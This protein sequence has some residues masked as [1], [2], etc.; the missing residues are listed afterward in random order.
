MR[1]KKVEEGYL[2]RLDPG[3]EV[4]SKLVD[5]VKAEQIPG[6]FITGMGAVERVT[7]G[8]YDYENRSYITKT[9]RDRLE[10][11]NLNGNI[12]YL[13]ETGDPFIHCHVTV[14]DSSL[15]SY[16]GHLFEAIVLV[17]VEIFIRPLKE[18]LMRHRNQE[19]GF[20]HWQL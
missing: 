3:E 14:G 20:N 18:K 19:V 16:T 13:E 2:I 10:V 1:Y 9:Y 7:I 4:L 12:T 15:N 17:T 11:G 5:F 8:F 6:G